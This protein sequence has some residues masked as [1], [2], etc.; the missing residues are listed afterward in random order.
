MATWTATRALGQ[1]G[2]AT[3]EFELGDLYGLSFVGQ[4]CPDTEIQFYGPFGEHVS[5]GNVSVQVCRFLTQKFDKVS[6]QNYIPA[7]WID[8]ELETHA[9]LYSEAPIGIFLGTP[10]MVPKLFYNHAFKIGGFVCETDAIDPDWA[11][12][13]NRLDLVF[14]PSNWCKAAFRNSGVKTPIIVVP[15]GIEEEY[16]PYPD[17]RTSSPIVFYNTFRASSFCSRKSLEELVRAFLEAFR[18]Q[19]DVVLRLRT[20]ESV[21][22]AEC[23]RKYSFGSL[24][25]QEE[26]K[27]MPTRD[28]ARIYSQVH[29]T[30]HPSKGEGFGLIP[31]Q[32]IACETPVIAPHQ[33]GMADYL[34][35]ENSVEL[36][37]KGRVEG[38]GVGNS[39]GTY[40]GIDEE[41]LVRQLRH[42]YSNWPEEHAKVK[43]AAPE[44]REQ[45]QWKNVLSEFVLLLDRIL[46]AE[47]DANRQR[48]LEPY[49]Q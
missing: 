10:D 16:R 39:H 6:I 12:I 43:R 26:L 25:A 23:K 5:M 3:I 7:P 14:V 47:T 45:Y 4:H 41:D 35:L 1:D 2:T 49:L 36:Q 42:V 29:C 27:E 13:C 44:F 20:N 9:G 21:K 22:L 24:I 11:D 46:G 15:H 17:E 8:E 40:F 33:T 37:I 30:V 32:S 48:S 18:G 31:F 34:T 38:E 28:F 19:D